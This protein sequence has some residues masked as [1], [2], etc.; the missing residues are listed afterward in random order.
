L[1]GRSGPSSRRLDAFAWQGPRERVDAGDISDDERRVIT[2]L[3]LQRLQIARVQLE[4]ARRNARDL[5]KSQ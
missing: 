3:A 1:I 2:A 4:L 5:G